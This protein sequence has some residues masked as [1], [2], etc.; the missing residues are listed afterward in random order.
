MNSI[1]EKCMEENTPKISEKIHGKAIEIF[2]NMPSYL[3]KKFASSMKMLDSS[4]PLKYLGYKHLTPKEEYKANISSGTKTSIDLASSTLYMVEY[5]FEYENE[6]FKKPLLLPYA[7]RGN[8]VDISNTAY[9]I[10]PVLSDRV[11]TPN[12]NGVFFRLDISKINVFAQSKNIRVNG[13]DTP[14]SVIYSSD[15]ARVTVSSDNIG[16]PVPPIA[17]YLFAKYGIDKTLQKYLKFRP[18][19]YIFGLYPKG[20][21]ECVH[22]D[23]EN[24]EENA[25]YEEKLALQKRYEEIKESGLYNIY[26]STKVR[27]RSH[28]DTIYEGQDT[29]IAIKKTIN[30]ETFHENM[31]TS[32]IYSLD[33]LPELG[34]DAYYLYEHAKNNP[35]DKDACDDEK[36]FWLLLLGRLI[37]KDAY[38]QARIIG[39]LRAHLNV[40]K[41]YLDQ[42]AK[43]LIAVHDL[44][45]FFDLIGLTLKDFN[46]WVMHYKEYNSDVENRYV[47]MDYYTSYDISY[48]FNKVI[49]NLNRR[50]SKT[51]GNLRFREVSKIF[52][53]FSAKKIYSLVKSSATN[54]TMVVASDVS[55]DLIYIKS[56]ANLEDQSR[57]NGVN[58]GAKSQFPQSTRFIKGQDMFIGSGWFLG[59]KSPSPRFKANIFFDYDLETGKSL[60]SEKN[61]RTASEIEKMLSG[62]IDGDSE[63]LKGLN[64]D[65]NLVEDAGD[66][67]DMD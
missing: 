50:K 17:L 39:D 61:L 45:D 48:T 54:L 63:E 8:I 40:L 7:K 60:I 22:T 31:I 19:D 25:E 52:S 18:D 38:S 4:I 1:L 49:L 24:D 5:L 58:R 47:D 59:K 27:P 66:Y 44:E 56:T 43:D 3:D 37:Y 21:L 33:M 34:D 29:Y 6:K 64:Q 57:G 10:G 51:A 9:T 12:D 41:G 55:S 20:E 36:E 42:T 67:S 23:E 32:I 2:K 62:R 15:I 14:T 13:R 35:T 65:V 46:K 28:R 16:K 26:E 11:I 30:I 53:E